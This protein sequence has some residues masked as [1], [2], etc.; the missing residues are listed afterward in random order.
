MDEPLLTF[1]G[2]GVAHPEPQGLLRYICENGFEHH[3]S[4]NPTRVGRCRQRSPGQVSWAGMFIG[5]V[6]SFVTDGHGWMTT[7]EVTDQNA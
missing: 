5:I 1:G 7:D 6:K 4:V 3:V 2:Y